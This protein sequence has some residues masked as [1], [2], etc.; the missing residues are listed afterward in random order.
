MDRDVTW[1]RMSVGEQISNIGSEVERALR[2]RE[3]NPARC[4]ESVNKAVELIERTQMDPKNRHR[5]RELGYCKEE[6]LDYFIGDNIYG[7]T[8]SQLRKYYDAFLAGSVS[9]R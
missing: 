8:D 4:L 6:L 2:F 1:Y 9:F 5:I 3:K 7:T